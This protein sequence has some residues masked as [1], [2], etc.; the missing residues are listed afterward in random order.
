LF[1]PENTLEKFYS[2]KIC[3]SSLQNSNPVLAQEVLFL[4]FQAPQKITS[5]DKT[6]FQS[7]VSLQ[8]AFTIFATEESLKYQ[9]QTR[10]QQELPQ[11][12]SHWGRPSGILRPI[13][14]SLPWKVAQRRQARLVCSWSS[15][16]NIGSDHS[17]LK[18]QLYTKGIRGW[19]LFYTKT[20]PLE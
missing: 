18:V 3:E 9:L 13:N 17:Y 11:S 15:E 4:T 20:V 5:L 16:Q 2:K 7:K 1:L 8:P 12:T 6:E 10:N 14:E 19:P